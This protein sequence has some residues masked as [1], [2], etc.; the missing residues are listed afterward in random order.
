M[1]AEELLLGLEAYDVPLVLA[2]QDWKT[3]E[4]F[5]LTPTAALKRYRR[6]GQVYLDEDIAESPDPYRIYL[7]GYGWLD[8]IEAKL[9][10]ADERLGPT[11]RGT[12]GV[13]RT[14]GM[15]DSILQAM[16]WKDEWVLCPRLL[17]GSRPIL[18]TCA[19]WLYT[20]NE[21][22]VALLNEIAEEKAAEAVVGVLRTPVLLAGRLEA[23]PDTPIQ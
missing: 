11:F 23:P 12:A 20:R 22:F 15:V 8:V 5:P 6:L 7:H 16:P 10:D 9:A 18:F 21:A 4:R 2:P 13:A 17:E 3:T 1:R 14:I 19:F